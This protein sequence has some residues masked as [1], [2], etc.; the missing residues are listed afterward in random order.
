MLNV[1]CIDTVLLHYVE[2]EKYSY[3]YQ[4]MFR[5]NCIVFLNILCCI[6]VHL[7]APAGALIVMMGY[8]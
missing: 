1:D 2:H 8:Q 7:L 3:Q 4:D 5:H 6:C